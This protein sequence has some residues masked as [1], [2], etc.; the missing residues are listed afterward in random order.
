VVASDYHWYRQSLRA[1]VLA[2][3]ATSLRRVARPG[4]WLAS[5]Y[6]WYPPELRG[7]VL[8]GPDVPCGESPARLVAR[9]GLRWYPPEQRADAPRARLPRAHAR[10]DVVPQG[11]GPPRRGRPATPLPPRHHHR[12]RGRSDRPAAATPIALATAPFITPFAPEP[13]RPL[14]PSSPRD[15]GTAPAMGRLRSP[16]LR[17]R[18]RRSCHRARS[19]SSIPP[20]ALDRPRRC[21]S[22]RAGSRWWPRRYCYR[23]T[24]GRPSRTR[25]CTALTSATSRQAGAR[26][27]HGVSSVLSD[28]E[29]V[30]GSGRW[31]RPS[32]SS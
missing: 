12:R 18:R 2:A 11:G 15:A 16:P 21:S 31:P 22:P 24:V 17:S 27:S 30:A 9:L 7:D 8:A 23:E 25:S 32:S 1:D 28:E 10:D 5:D 20:T 14:P 3:S 26:H 29:T 4:W 19:P 6:R 13:A